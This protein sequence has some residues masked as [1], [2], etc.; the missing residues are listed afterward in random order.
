MLWTSEGSRCALAAAPTGARARFI[1][2]TAALVVVMG[3]LV[4]CH[5]NSETR[6]T[7]A[8]TRQAVISDEAHA[9]PANGFFFLPPMVKNPNLVGEFAR[10]LSPEVQIDERD[11]ASPQVVKRIIATYTVN[12]GPDRQVV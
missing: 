8:T 1:R 2:A 12:S 4:G 7:L 5:S 11:P 9:G 6:E 3:S 10:N